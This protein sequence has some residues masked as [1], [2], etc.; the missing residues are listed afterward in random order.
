MRGKTSATR[1]K[2][3]ILIQLLLIHSTT[4]IIGKTQLP[5]SVYH[6]EQPV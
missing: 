3:K 5:R 6:G 1:L 2:L 4:I